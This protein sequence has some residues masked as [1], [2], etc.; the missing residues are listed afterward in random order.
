MWAH[1]A[2]RE[3]L[4][5]LNAERRREQLD[6]ISCE[7]F[8]IAIDR[9]EKEWFALMKQIPSKYAKEGGSSADAEEPFPED[10]FCAICDDGE[11]ENSNAIVFCDG[12]NL[13]VHQDCYGIP[14]IP[15]GQ[16]LCRKCTVSP[17]R[18]VSCVLCPAEG[19][20]F[21]QTTQG[22]WAHLLCAMWIPE[23]GVGNTVYM[24]PIDGVER[25][26]KARWRLRCYLCNGRGGACIQCEHRSCFTAFHVVCAR[27]AGLLTRVRRQI[28]HSEETEQVLT[29]HCHHHLPRVQKL[30]LR[31]RLRGEDYREVHSDEDADS[32]SSSES[33]VSESDVAALAQRR[34]RGAASAQDTLASKSARAYNRLYS[35]GPLPVP[36]Y[37]VR[38]VN[39]H[40][41]RIALRRKPQTIAQ[42]VRY[43]SLKRERTR[44]APLLKRLHIEPWTVGNFVDERTSELKLRKLQFLYRLREDLE[45]VRLL[46]ELV[47]KREKQKT[48]GAQ[49]LR[50]CVLDDAVLM[51]QRQLRDTLDRV[52]A[53]DRADLFRYPVSE[54]DAPDYYDVVHQPMDWNT[55]AR[56]IDA[57]EY[58]DADAFAADVRRVYANAMLYNAPDTPYYKAA[59][60]MERQTAPLLDE[61]QRAMRATNEGR[62]LEPPDEVVKML[63]APPAPDAG[64]RHIGYPPEDAALLDVLLTQCYPVHEAVEAP[65]GPPATPKKHART[66]REPQQPSRRSRRHAEPDAAE[67]KPVT[68]PQPIDKPQQ[69]TAVNDKDSFR[70]FNVGWLL[71]PGTRRGNRPRPEP[72]PAR[73]RRKARAAPRPER[74]STRRQAEAPNA[75]KRGRPPGSLGRRRGR[76]PAASSASKRGRATDSPAPR[77]RTR[78]TPVAPSDT[79]SD[80]SDAPTEDL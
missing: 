38:R 8:E 46:A 69:V 9:L 24:E 58:D 23:T 3:W 74:A 4:E 59:Q 25:I 77:K 1:R 78:R 5:A 48:R 10:S 26:P 57:L 27:R 18:P 64:E 2:D 43:W 14:Y 47:R 17:D 75:P 40:L 54:Q 16:W 50:S 29:A 39:D 62:G 71:P 66:E 6:T 68:P 21:K 20:A 36:N 51:R 33:D 65:A 61:L 34:V 63:R 30:A 32:G 79:S 45:K 56:R 19:G 76:T 15:E 31:A 44:G 67:T 73:G 70:Y 37:I 53:L 41:A 11:C 12:C 28:E 55:V 35:A 13:A 22:K 49:L 80:L 52:M 7:T 42:I 72:R 60:K